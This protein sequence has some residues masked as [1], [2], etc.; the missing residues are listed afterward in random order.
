[1]SVLV[2]QGPST[3]AIAALCLAV[4]GY[5]SS[6]RFPAL[7]PV[8]PRLA[9][10]WNPFS[11]TLQILRIAKKTRS[12]VVAARDLLV[13]VLRRSVSDDIARLRAEHAGCTRARSHL[14]FL[15]QPVTRSV[16]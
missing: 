3:V 6:R 5:L 15:A 7:P 12:L 4:V 8:A 16:A 11:P 9:V 10:Q 14:I 1:V 2:K 13:L